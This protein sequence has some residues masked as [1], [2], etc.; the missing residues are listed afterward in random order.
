MG[1]SFIPVSADK[2]AEL[3][4]QIAAKV[5]TTILDISA[6][7]AATRLIQVQSITAQ[8]VSKG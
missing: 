8:I 2:I 4:A 5:D 3:A 6:V 7:N 1:F